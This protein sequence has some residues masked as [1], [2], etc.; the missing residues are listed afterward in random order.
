MNDGGGC[1][2]G[3]TSPRRE[4]AAPQGLRLAQKP[5]PIARRAG[6]SWW[7][8]A[9][10]RLVALQQEQQEELRWTIEGLAEATSRREEPSE[11]SA[12]VMKTILQRMFSEA[13]QEVNKSGVKRHLWTGLETFPVQEKLESQW[14]GP[15][16]SPQKGLEGPDLQQR[17]NA[18]AGDLR[19]QD[20]VQM[21]ANIFQAE[22]Q[23]EQ[24]SLQLQGPS[25]SLQVLKGFQGDPNVQDAKG[26]HSGGSQEK[27]HLET[28]HRKGNGNQKL[29]GP[30]HLEFSQRQ[31]ASQRDPEIL[32]LP[33]ELSHEP[34]NIPGLSDKKESETISKGEISGLQ[35]TPEQQEMLECTGTLLRMEEISQLWKPCGGVKVLEIHQALVTPDMDQMLPEK[36]E[37]NTQESSSQGFPFHRLCLDNLPPQGEILRKSKSLGCLEFVT[38]QNL[39]LQGPRDPES[40]LQ[41][42]SERLQRAPSPRTQMET[43]HSQQT[44]SSLQRVLQGEAEVIQT[45]T[46]MKTIILKSHISPQGKQEPQ[47]QVDSQDG[48]N[49]KT[50]HTQGTQMPQPQDC[51]ELELVS[52]L[53]KESPTLHIGE[54]RPSKDLCHQEQKVPEFSHCQGASMK[55][56]KSLEPQ[57]LLQTRA[58][59]SGNSSQIPLE[60]KYPQDPQCQ[61]WKKIRSQDISEREVLKLSD[62]VLQHPNIPKCEEV[63]QIPGPE[64]S[65]MKEKLDFQ[66][67]E[68]PSK[69][70]Q[71]SYPQ[72]QTL[73]DTDLL[74]TQKLQKG[75]SKSQGFQ[76][77]AEKEPEFQ[78]DL[79]RK[80]KS[81]KLDKKP[82]LQDE[83]QSEELHIPGAMQRIG[84]EIH[85][86]QEAQLEWPVLTLRESLALQP[87]KLVSQRQEG[88]PAPQDFRSLESPPLLWSILWRKAKSFEQVKPCVLLGP[89]QGQAAI[90]RISKKELLIPQLPQEIKEALLV[91]QQEGSLV[92]TEHQ[93][94]QKSNILYL[95]DLKQMEVMPQTRTEKVVL[96]EKWIQTDPQE[97]QHQGETTSEILLEGTIG[98]VN[99]GEIQAFHPQETGEMEIPSSQEA[100]QRRLLMLPRQEISERELELL[101]HSGSFLQEDL[102]GAQ[103]LAKENLEKVQIQEN[104]LLKEIFV[105]QPQECRSLESPPLLWG[106]TGLK[107]KSFEL[108]TSCDIEAHELRESPRAQLCRRSEM[109]LKSATLQKCK[110]PDVIS[111]QDVRGAES[112]LVKPKIGNFHVGRILPS[113]SQESQSPKVKNSDIPHSQ[114]PESEKTN[115]PFLREK[116]A[117]LG[118]EIR[119]ME[120]PQTWVTSQEKSE[121]SKT[122]QRVV[123]LTKDPGMAV[124][125]LKDQQ[126]PLPSRTKCLET[127]LPPEECRHLEPSPLLGRALEIKAKSF[128]LIKSQA[129]QMSCSEA[130]AL[131]PPISQQELQAHHIQERTKLEMILPS[132]KPQREPESQETQKDGAPHVLH[133]T[134]LREPLATQVQ[135][136][137]SVHTQTPGSISMQ[138]LLEDSKEVQA[139]EPQEL[140]DLEVPQA[141]ADPQSDKILQELEKP[142]ILPPRGK[143][144]DALTSQPVPEIK[145]EGLQHTE[146]SSPETP[147]L[148]WWVLELAHQ[149]ILH[150][151]LQVSP[152]PQELSYYVPG[153]QTQGPQTEPEA[154]NARNQNIPFAKKLQK[155]EASQPQKESFQDAGIR[156]TDAHLQSQ[157][158]IDPKASQ[159]HEIV[160]QGEPISLELSISQAFQF[161]AQEKAKPFQGLKRSPQALEV[162][163]LKEREPVSIEESSKRDVQSTE[164]PPVKQKTS[165]PIKAKGLE[166]L[167]QED[168]SKLCDSYKVIQCHSHQTLGT[169]GNLD[170]V[171]PSSPSAQVQGLK[172][173]DS[174]YCGLLNGSQFLHPKEIAN[175]ETIKRVKQ[176]VLEALE[177]HSKIKVFLPLEKTLGKSKSFDLWELQVLKTQAPLKKEG[178]QAQTTEVLHIQKDLPKKHQEKTDSQTISSQEQGNQEQDTPQL[179]QCHGSASENPSGLQSSFKQTSELPEMEPCPLQIQELR[180][181][182]MLQPQSSKLQRAMNSK[183]FCLQ[184]HHEA[185]SW[186][187]RVEDNEMQEILQRYPQS[188]LVQGVLYPQADAF[189]KSKSLELPNTNIILLQGLRKPDISQS[190]E[191][192]K[193]CPRIL[194]NQASSQVMHNPL[195]EKETGS[196]TQKELKDSKPQEKLGKNKPAI[197]NLEE[198]KVLQLQGQKEIEG[199][200]SPGI[201]QMEHISLQIQGSLQNNPDHFGCRNLNHSVVLQSEKHSVIP[202]TLEFVKHVKSLTL[203]PLAS[204]EREALSAWWT[205]GKSKSLD[206]RDH[207]ALCLKSSLGELDCSN[208]QNIHSANISQPQRDIQDELIEQWKCKTPMAYSKTHPLEELLSKDNIC[209]QLQEEN[210]C[211]TQ[212]TE[213]ME[214]E[215]QQSQKLLRH[216]REI[217]SFR[218]LGDIQ[219]LCSKEYR[220][221]EALQLQVSSQSLKE[222]L[223]INQSVQTESK[224][225]GLRKPQHL[226]HQEERNLQ[227][228]PL[229]RN[230]LRKSKTFG[231]EE[232]TSRVD[233]QIQLVQKE[234]KPGEQDSL[235]VE[236]QL[237]QR[238][239]GPEPHNIQEIS[240]PEVLQHQEIA[241]VERIWESTGQPN[242]PREAHTI[243][244]ESMKS[245]VTLY[246][247]QE[248]PQEQEDTPYV[249][250]QSSIPQFVPPHD[251]PQFGIKFLQ[252][253]GRL[254]NELNT[255]R[256]QELKDGKAVYSQG[257]KGFS[258]PQQ[259]ILAEPQI[260]I[261]SQVLQHHKWSATTSPQPPLG[262]FSEAYKVQEVQRQTLQSPQSQR[263]D[264]I[265]EIKRESERNMGSPKQKA[266]Q[267]VQLQA[268]LPKKSAVVPGMTVPP[269]LQSLETVEVN[270]L[271]LQESLNVE[272]KVIEKKPGAIE[273]E[274]DHPSQMQKALMAK[275]K[276]LEPQSLSRTQEFQH[277][278][279]NKVDKEMATEHIPSSQEPLNIQPRAI[280]SQ[281]QEFSTKQEKGD[282]GVLL[283]QKEQMAQQGDKR[284]QGKHEMLKLPER[285]DLKSWQSQKEQELP[286]E[287]GALQLQWTEGKKAFQEWRETETLPVE[288]AQPR[289]LSACEKGLLNLG[290]LEPE[291]ESRRLETLLLWEQKTTEATAMTLLSPSS[292]GKHSEMMW[293]PSTVN[294]G[295]SRETSFRVAQ[296]CAPSWED[297]VHISATSPRDSPTLEK[298]TDCPLPGE[299]NQKAMRTFHGDAAEGRLVAEG[300]DGQLLRP[301]HPPSREKAFIWLSP[302]DKKEAL[303]RL[304]ETQAAG[305]R[306]H[307]RDKERQ[308][309]WFQER[310]SIAKRWRSKEDLLGDNPADRWP[311]AS[312]A[313]E[314]QDEAGQ[315]MAVKYHLEKVKRE[316]TYVMQSKRERNTLKFKELLGPLVAPREENPALRP[317]EERKQRGDLHPSGSPGQ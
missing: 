221:L 91:Q 118:Q 224:S 244:M 222:P 296:P 113:Y 35:N 127:L 184:G 120:S 279:P 249:V 254:H 193:E 148:L 243:E 206:L 13:A 67:Q 211:A 305:E 248:P 162:H 122:E 207:E 1:S 86:S 102:S 285:R 54:M 195:Q 24:K 6:A 74:H 145:A 299:P 112:P 178:L 251:S 170:S 69:E 237:L 85:Q 311:W 194:D 105:P 231:Y 70:I 275:S 124:Q 125:E 76:P 147:P 23:P 187:S 203:L 241:N 42:L 130:A 101:K 41:I 115:S 3:E 239:E 291:A 139:L 301:P 121:S 267:M 46:K 306:R 266:P 47:K 273:P 10:T 272:G 26:L 242:S 22:R 179:L 73:I 228:L 209:Q 263:L 27:K 199:L 103:P 297:S 15:G 216:E 225:Q 181:V 235:H 265:P 18:S 289:N 256:P 312:A 307:Q 133:K 138:H 210:S 172:T 293:D 82:R 236:R 32:D 200:H 277:E 33:E 298:A 144:V 176:G 270:S 315:K 174:E 223:H 5:L 83:S 158:Y 152:Q 252:E 29:V 259:Q 271:D 71:L 214:L 34:Q 192:V 137:K 131:T 49:E 4:E 287:M 278:R 30:L 31:N 136:G 219:M 284:F 300:V 66:K 93:K 260:N 65:M 190:Q 250:P 229:M 208:L 201:P 52:N 60:N 63:I 220:K 308:S 261:S 141:Q 292:P 180:D 146:R 21:D 28:P 37:C 238:F 45:E 302:Q 171:C 104:V 264:Q 232:L 161:L 149:G 79:A 246:T 202:E 157:E 188:F 313:S 177:E 44:P 155:L 143:N 96:V 160:P 132:E 163:L 99:L 165:I 8:C 20:T 123:E 108:R 240:K 151:E 191:N 84:R 197:L 129:F 48:W 168:T 59:E 213:Y 245:K 215:A 80:A 140:R 11:T 100:P 116:E 189:R 173:R 39:L 196:P 55:K 50:F 255:L 205:L 19:V 234:E 218:K 183:T 257:A 92:E 303:Q 12:L 109:R 247:N 128:E 154:Q 295:I 68:V 280:S 269:S 281:S 16:L 135:A 36:K 169:L 159:P 89:E 62:S 268:G 14:K 204:T 230:L 57:E 61:E 314:G 198:N 212:K 7:D 58:S 43:V 106:V 164:G 167:V 226:N 94:L 88:I 262:D 288:G 38:P 185:E 126:N 317:A 111:P 153:T 78:T 75:L 81:L 110:G 56:S 98:Q 77:H 233:P 217:T 258:Q 53:H 274:E 290:N 182:V 310:L 156:T 142:E 95:Q 107:S 117:L 90:Q 72:A 294:M 276:S 2:G 186:E 175:A 283:N 286:R 114:E 309:L 17:T 316:R 134:D 87:Q 119:E 51:E 25:A 64:T 282:W 304:A 9:V 150:R 227:S 97:F 253:L 166:G 40:S